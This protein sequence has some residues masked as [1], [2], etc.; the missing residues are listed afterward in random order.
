MD[1][2]ELQIV[3]T[4]LRQIHEAQIIRI[5]NEGFDNE[6]GRAE[7]VCVSHGGHEFVDIGRGVVCR[8]C[9][10]CGAQQND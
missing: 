1:A 3:I 8:K 4:E 9:K 6:Q 2:A 5:T 7:E 10:F